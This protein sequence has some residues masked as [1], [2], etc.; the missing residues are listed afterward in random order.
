M[1][2]EDENE[3]FDSDIKEIQKGKGR[4]GFKNKNQVKDEEKIET[5]NRFL[6]ETIKNDNKKIFKKCLVVKQNK[7][8]NCCYE[9]KFPSD[10]EN[11]FEHLTYYKS[12]MNIVVDGNIS[13]E[14]ILIDE[15]MELQ[16]K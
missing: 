11:I 13:Y 4:K 15:K 5:F 10:D 12:G 6:E 2:E 1:I 3:E 9:L 7:Y 16:I 8:K 14:N